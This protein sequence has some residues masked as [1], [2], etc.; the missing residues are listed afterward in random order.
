MLDGIWFAVLVDPDQLLALFSEDRA[1]PCLESCLDSTGLR[2]RLYP[3]LDPQCE[4]LRV[5]WA[6]DTGLM[7]RKSGVVV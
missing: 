2:R 7:L 5:C 1:L 6:N 3:E 4:V